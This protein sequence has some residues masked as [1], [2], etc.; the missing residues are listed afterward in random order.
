MS[1]N[2]PVAVYCG[3]S[4]GNRPAFAAAAKSLGF[5]L[6]TSGRPLVYGGGSKGIMGIV[7]GAALQKEG[8]V[9]GVIPRAMVAAGGEKDKVNENNVHVL[10]DE[11]GREKVE[12][13]LVDSMH[14]RKVEM[15]K[16]AEAF[17]GLP[18][19]F[20][21]FEEVLEVTTWSQLGIHDKPVILLN[22]LS[23]WEPLRTLVK[24]SINAGFIH[25]ANERLIIFVDGPE[26]HDEHESF[27]WGKAA[28]EAL[29]NW[30]P[31][32]TRPL[33]SWKNES[34]YNKT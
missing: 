14:E 12:T 29:D 11:P 32:T 16:R 17:F 10:L 8:K 21:T 25:A 34:S 23:F 18:G 33:F 30:S 3:A 15:A 6:A 24:Q 31:G 28:L 2:P 20:G 19:G 22:V 26:D 7:S 9:I 5:A 13:I 4:I 27:D 1:T